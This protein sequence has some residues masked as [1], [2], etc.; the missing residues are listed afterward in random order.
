MLQPVIGALSYLHGQGFS[1]G[2]MKPSNILAV[3]EQVKISSDG[4]C[5]IGAQQKR[6]STYDAPELS[7]TGCSSA[8]DA[9]SLGLTLAQALTQQVPRWQE[10]TG[11]E[12]AL[13]GAVP[14]PFWDIARNCLRRD[15]ESRWTTK[16]ILARLQPS[17][18]PPAMRP[19]A[20][21][22]IAPARAP[23]NWQRLVLATVLVA[24]VGMI[25]LVTMKIR[26]RSQNRQDEVAV[27]EPTPAA[28]E[29]TNKTTS[30]SP[31]GAITVE[32]KQNAAAPTDAAP[33]S[34]EP[35]AAGDQATKRVIPE[36]PQKARDT[37]H[38]TV[39][40]GIRVD[41]DPSGQVTAVSIDSPG[42]SGYFANLAA[43]AARRWTFVPARVDDGMT[44]RTWILRFEF[45]QAATKVFPTQLRQ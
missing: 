14:Q 26:E 15:P 36:V 40:V 1:H 13:L 17:H 31:H 25:V 19:E 41:V 18:P 29:K 38:G 22:K 28:A 9:W 12:P 24:L 20:A 44:H 7:R 34:A 39:K 21:P 43:G 8:A 42:P 33:A 32:T 5:P 3:G 2:C 35:S 4:I 27:P 10:S 37:I 16:D 11:A 23:T 45:T 30:P 6:S